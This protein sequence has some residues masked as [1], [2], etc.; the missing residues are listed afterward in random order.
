MSS[1]FRTFDGQEYRIGE[2]WPPVECF[3]CGV[4]CLRY[5]PTVSPEE[6]KKIATA[7]G[8]AADEFFSTYVRTTAKGDGFVLGSSEEGCIFLSWE[9][10]SGKAICAIHAFMPKAC[11]DWI[12]SLSRPECQQGLAKLKPNATIMTPD[13]LYPSEKPVAK[14]NIAALGHS[15]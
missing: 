1:Y 14:L 7:L 2:A 10:A 13:Q 15:E 9:E 3:R 8:I 12:P 6:I 4:C 5:R 11:R